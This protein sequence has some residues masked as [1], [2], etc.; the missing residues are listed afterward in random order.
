MSTAANRKVKVGAVK[1]PSDTTADKALPR[2]LKTANNA[3]C[4]WVCACFLI[5]FCQSLKY[6]SIQQTVIK[7]SLIKLHFYTVMILPLA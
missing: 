1:G 2:N 4:R 5:I 7:T 6:T 3:A